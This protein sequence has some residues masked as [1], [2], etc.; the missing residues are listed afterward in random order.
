MFSNCLNIK[1]ATKKYPTPFYL[2]FFQTL[3][4]FIL[5]LLF[6]YTHFTYKLLLADHRVLQ[7]LRVLNNVLLPITSTGLLGELAKLLRIFQ[8][9]S[10]E[11]RVET[12]LVILGLLLALLLRSIRSLLPLS[13]DQTEN[14]G[15][16]RL[17]V[18]L[19][20]LGSHLLTKEDIRT[21]SALHIIQPCDRHLLFLLRTLRTSGELWKRTRTVHLNR[22][23]ELRVE[24]LLVL[25]CPSIIGLA[26]FAAELTPFRRKSLHYKVRSKCRV[27]LLKR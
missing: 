7:H 22:S 4:F 13:C 1:N 20:D 14:L 16:R 6:I 27:L 19:H 21:L 24:T 23:L 5:V 11:L 15:G 12:L 17:W 3:L 8:N 26:S 18:L 25:L 2:F 9:R 10:L